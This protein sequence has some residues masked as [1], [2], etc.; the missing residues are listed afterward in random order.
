MCNGSQGAQSP[1]YKRCLFKF[2]LPIAFKNVGP[3]SIS[4]TSYKV[5][6]TE[7][8]KELSTEGCSYVA[9][10]NLNFFSCHITTLW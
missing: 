1:I 3:K 5:N 10:S 9:V 4:E 6:E 8:F 2:L 7:Q